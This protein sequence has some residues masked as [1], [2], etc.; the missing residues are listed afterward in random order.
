MPSSPEVSQ[1]QGLIRFIEIDSKIE[2]HQ[3]S[4]TDGHIAVAAEIA[5][6]LQGVAIHRHQVFEAAVGARCRKNEIVVLCHIIGQHSL[7]EKSLHDQEKPAL[8]FIR[9]HD[10]FVLQLGQEKFRT[11]NRPRHQMR[12]ETH[13]ECVVQKVVG[14]LQFT[15]ID[16]NDVA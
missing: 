16:I 9:I 14:W 7:F 5:V 13:V 15:L 3:Q 11:Y 4:D 6:N 1:R 10:D 8:Y 12:K 2:S